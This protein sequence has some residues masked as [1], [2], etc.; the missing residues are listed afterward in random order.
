[1][2]SMFHQPGR[3]LRGNLH[4]HTTLSDG[5]TPLEEAIA[6]YKDAGYDFVAVTDHR[7]TVDTKAFRTDNFLTIPSIELNGRDP[8]LDA[9]YHVVGLGVQPFAQEDREWVAPGRVMVEKIKAMGGI[10]VLAHPYWS[11]NDT[12][13]L[14]DLQGVTALEVYNA[15]CAR[16]GKESSRVHWDALLERGWHIWGAA[17][18]DTHRYQSDGAQA[19]VMVKAAALEE[20]AILA[21]LQAG[22]FYAT[23]GPAILDF[24][25]DEESIWVHCSPVREV[26]F[27]GRRGSGKTVVAPD[28]KTICSAR[29]QR[30][31]SPYVRVECI[32]AQGKTAWTQ[33][34]FYQGGKYRKA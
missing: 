32:D 31:K 8:E 21:A 5:D 29:M 16:H 17:T 1:M 14:L 28:G 22:Q 24:D 11:G 34:I 30:L 18:D 6:F 13:D 4:M 7:L 10:A 33:P 20:R 9:I 12:A 23:T 3:W 19:W 2:D 25:M 26:R 27:I 15:T